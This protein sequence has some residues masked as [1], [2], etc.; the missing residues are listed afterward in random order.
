WG[1][2]AEVYRNIY[3]GAL[4]CLHSVDQGEATLKSA[5]KHPSIQGRTDNSWGPWAIGI[6]GPHSNH[7]QKSL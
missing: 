1:P 7:T 2:Y 6:M 5:T 3:P 4:W